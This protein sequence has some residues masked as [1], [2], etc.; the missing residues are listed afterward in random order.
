MYFVAA[1]TAWPCTVCIAT[2]AARLTE[3]PRPGTTECA[4]CDDKS[5]ET[6][7]QLQGS[8]TPKCEIPWKKLKN[9]PR[10]PTPKTKKKLKKYQ[11]YRK[12]LFLSIFSIFFV[13][14]EE[15]GVG[16]R[17]YFL[18]FFRGISGFGVLDPCSWPGVSQDKRCNWNCGLQK[19]NT[20]KQKSCML[21]YWSQGCRS[22]DLG[23]GMSAEELNFQDPLNGPDLFTVGHSQPK[24]PFLFTDCCFIASPS[25]NSVPKGICLGG[26][27]GPKKKI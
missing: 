18:S 26:H 6:P 7:G 14:F 20:Q 10:T 3:W 23:M 12:I 1:F 17:G 21:S 19:V 25:P 27:F 16:V 24:P 22:R 2:R 11:K 4:V 13:F 8:K 5:W 9:Y 15:F